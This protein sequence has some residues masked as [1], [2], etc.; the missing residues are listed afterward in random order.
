MFAAAV[1]PIAAARASIVPRPHTRI[2]ALQL[3]EL[4][5]SKDA[6]A[7][8][9][10]QQTLEFHYGKHHNAYV[11]NLNKLIEGTDLANAPLEEIVKAAA[12]NASKAGLFNNAAQV[13]NHTFYWHSMKPGGGGA[14]HGKVAELI[15]RDFGSYEEFATQFKAAGGGQFGSG[16]AWLVA[17]KEGKLKVFQTHDAG[18]PL[19][20][21]LT[22]LLTC[23]VWEHAFYIDYKNDKAKYVQSFWGAVNWD[24]VAS[25]FPQGELRASKL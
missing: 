3:P 5:Y 8:H 6:L 7:P 11:T 22:P 4:P 23:D 1:S 10:N 13:W 19:T 20:E 21:G 24:F 16:W 12:S 15:E 9:I 18:C 17:D 14:P 25:N 2:M